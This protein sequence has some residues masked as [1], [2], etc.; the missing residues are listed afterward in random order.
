MS[1]YWRTGDWAY[2]THI[3]SLQPTM[4]IKNRKY[5]SN[6]RNIFSANRCNKICYSLRKTMF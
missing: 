4:Y 5:K 1:A 6:V 2:Y 3:V